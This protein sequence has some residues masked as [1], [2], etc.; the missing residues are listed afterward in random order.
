ME[1]N[2][3][4][5]NIDEFPWTVI[6][7]PKKSFYS[8]SKVAMRVASKEQGGS[9]YPGPQIVY[10]E[11]WHHVETFYVLDPVE[12]GIYVATSLHDRFHYQIKKSEEGTVLEQI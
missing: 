3:T 10:P 2:N 4:D 8:N 1:N 12:I 7:S 5:I 9:T 11:R 6:E